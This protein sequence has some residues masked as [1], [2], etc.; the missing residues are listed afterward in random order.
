[1]NN[2]GFDKD[3][4]RQVAELHVAV[5]CGD[6]KEK[7]IGELQQRWT[8]RAGDFTLAE[9]LRDGMDRSVRLDVREIPKYVKVVVYD[10]V[11]DR[12]GSMSVKLK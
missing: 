6:A 10:P 7:V 11:S 12:T 2:V 3:G 9:W 5:Y 1:M 4:D 8:V